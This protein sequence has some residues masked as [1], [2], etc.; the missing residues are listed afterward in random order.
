MHQMVGGQV[1]N[2]IIYDITSQLALSYNSLPMCYGMEMTKEGTSYCLH[3]I[4]EYLHLGCKYR[5]LAH[6]L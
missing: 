1:N 3:L 4:N 5:R 6:V 2:I